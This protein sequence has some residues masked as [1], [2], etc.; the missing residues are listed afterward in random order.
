[1]SNIKIRSLGSGDFAR[2]GFVVEGKYDFT[3]LLAVLAANT[4]CPT[5]RVIY[6]P[7]CKALHELPI[8]RQL[9][10]SLYGDMPLQLGY[11]NGHNLQLGCL[12]YH[13]GSEF[14]IAT[15]PIV[16]LVADLRDIIG[17]E[18]DTSEVQAFWVPAGTAVMLYETTLHYAPCTA[19]GESGFR[20][21][22]GLPQGT[23]LI[24]Q[25]PD[26]MTVEGR[27]LYATNKWLYAHPD[28]SEA[29]S[30]AYVGLKGP[31]IVLQY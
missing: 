12:E 31:D 14:I 22:I 8:Y 16:L 20:A 11:C 25:E 27:A 7:E 29:K 4:D 1:M 10:D 13:R 2:Y 18:I 9:R 3:E 15:T 5:E 24:M 26:E 17:G 19:P 6:E 28:S 23:N 30:G 21:V